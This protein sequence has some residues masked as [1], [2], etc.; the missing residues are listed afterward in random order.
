MLLKK[1]RFNAQHGRRQSGGS[2]QSRPFELKI[3]GATDVQI[4]LAD[5]SRSFYSLIRFG[6]RQ[7]SRH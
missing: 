2:Q 7:I 5:F 4:I 1:F 6:S 3:S